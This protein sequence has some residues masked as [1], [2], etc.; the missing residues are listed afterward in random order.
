MASEQIFSKIVAAK[1]MPADISNRVVDARTWLRDRARDVKRT[2]PERIVSAKSNAQNMH[3]RV[4]V[5]HM[6]MFLYDPKYKDTLPFYD[7][8]P[9]IFPFEK[10]QGGFYGLNMHYLP[11][12]LRAR[13]MDQLYKLINNSSYDETTRLRLSY[14][15]L[16]S[17]SQFRY[18]TPCVKHYLNNH[19][20]SRFLYI[21]PKEWDTALFLPTERFQKQSKQQV[22]NNTIRTLGY[23]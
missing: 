7:R 23:K 18:F 21:H 6:Y 22:F 3:N 19:V 1:T 2:Y 14:K 20:K 10:V 15:I 9:L 4:L 5:G 13:L 16:K 12:L 11:Y 17:S 8:F